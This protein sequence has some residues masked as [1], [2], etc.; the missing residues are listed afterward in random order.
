MPLHHI[1]KA[2][3]FLSPVLLYH[4]YITHFLIQRIFTYLLLL[5]RLLFL[6]PGTQFPFGG[7]SPGGL[8]SPPEAEAVC[9]HC[10]QILTA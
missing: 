9:R 3:P 5:L 6:N 4:P 7:Y 1:R 8:G 10:L 2:I